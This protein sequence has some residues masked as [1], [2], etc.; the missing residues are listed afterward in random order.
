MGASDWAGHMC[1]TLE[2]RF[3]IHGDRSVRLTTMVRFLRGEGAFGEYDSDQYEE[4]V[5]QLIDNLDDSLATQPGET[6]EER[7]NN[8]MDDLGCQARTER[9][10][11]LIPWDDHEAEAWDKPGR[12]ATRPE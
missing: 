3:D 7:W 10:V 2:D 1:L 11:Y 5:H 6:V 12:T 8:L 9:G 4:H